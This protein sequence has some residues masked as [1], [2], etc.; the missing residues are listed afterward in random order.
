MTSSEKNHVPGQK[1]SGDRFRP[2]HRHRRTKVFAA[3]GHRSSTAARPTG[4]AGGR[5]AHADGSAAI[6]AST[7]L[8]RRTWPVPLPDQAASRGPDPGNNACHLGW[9]TVRH[10]DHFFD[11]V[12]AVN[13]RGYALVCRPP[14]GWSPGAAGPSSMVQHGRRALPAPH[15]LQGRRGNH[16]RPSPSNWPSTT[17]ASTASFPASSAPNAGIPFPKVKQRRWKNV[18]L[19][20]IHP[21]DR[22][23]AAFRARAATSPDPLSSSRCLD[24]SCPTHCRVKNG[25]RSGAWLAVEQPIRQL[26]DA[27]IAPRDRFARSIKSSSR[28]RL[29]QNNHYTCQNCP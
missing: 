20:E 23:A 3:C 13:L 5:N 11:E 6:F 19:G 9:A 25:A 15:R 21:E 4:G 2:Q 22:P 14:G 24:I 28:R 8:L 16:T 27:R 26:Q 7:S 12:L 29:P 17:S 18:P 1:R 10:A